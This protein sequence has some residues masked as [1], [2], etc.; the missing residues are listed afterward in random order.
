MIVLYAATLLMG[1]V[2]TAAAVAIIGVQS[3]LDTWSL[4][5]GIFAGGLLGL[6]LLE[7]VSKRAGNL[8][9]IVGVSLGVCTILCEWS[10]RSKACRPTSFTDV[11]RRSCFE[12]SKLE[13]KTSCS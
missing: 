9:A 1:T 3:I 7:M 4:L 8:A 5:S 10:T 12:R 13:V 6:F 2:G 11:S